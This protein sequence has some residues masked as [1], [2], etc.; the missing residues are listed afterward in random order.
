MVEILVAL[1]AP[2]SIPAFILIA[3]V[4]GIVIAKLN[5]Y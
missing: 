5:D 1:T 4:C 2:Y 3:I